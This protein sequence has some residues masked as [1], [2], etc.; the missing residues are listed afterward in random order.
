MN[1]N[2][3]SSLDVEGFLERIRN[4]SNP[5]LQ[6]LIQGL[7]SF[8]HIEEADDKTSVKVLSDLITVLEEYEKRKKYGGHL[9]GWFEES[10]P[11]G[12]DKLPKHR[13][14]FDAGE[15][16]RIRAFIA[17][18]RVG[19]TVAS[20]YEAACH[21]TGLYPDWW[22][23][24]RF[25]RPVKVWACG[26]SWGQV[27]ETILSK[28]YG[29]TG[30]PGTGLISPE[31]ILKTTAASGIPGALES[32]V[33]KHTSGGSSVIS[34]KT[35]EQ[36]IR[37]FQG[38]EVD[39]VLMDEEPPYDIYDECDVRLMT[40]G[41]IM[42]MTFTPQ[43]GLTP[44]IVSLYRSADLLMGS[45]PLPEQV[46]LLAAREAAGDN[47]EM[48]S[49][50]REYE[51]KTVAVVQVSM[52]DVPWL[53]EEMIED[54][55][56]K[57][58]PHL[59]NSRIYGKVTVGEGTI[60]PVD[61]DNLIVTPFQIPPYWKRSFGM[62][63]GWNVTAC[64]WG[65]LDPDTDVLYIYSEYKGEQKEPIIHS[66]AIKQ[67]GDWITGSIDYQANSP[68]AETGRRLMDIYRSHGLRLVGA[69]KAVDA[70]ILAVLERMT[71]GRLKIFSNCFNLLSEIPVYRRDKNGKVVKE[72]D[73][74]VDSLRYLVMGL[75][76][77]RVF[78]HNPHRDNS[79]GENY[80]E[81]SF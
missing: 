67:R 37:A 44:T 12:I 23:G 19:K 22:K 18:N 31:L 63:V 9:E 69:D 48:S 7:E 79:S 8:K 11:F 75:R 15:K 47:D 30:N 27:K 72:H 13:A 6:S 40:T 78:S 4:E 25:N 42:M 74:F 50:Y 34:F 58:P 14:F 41:G 43:M 39:V 36:G 71:T 54:R 32:I 56:R 5:A 3:G 76:H 55:K 16:Y 52:Y 68:S 46:M 51:E 2:S 62:D 21:A 24:K 49:G 28:L 70:G 20:T 60:Y 38:A 65:A 77:A 66:H 80:R 81:Y 45:E 53:S 17:G 35:Y 26:I 61:L 59:V 1:R 57:S 33:V 29:T 10:T 73:H 64:V